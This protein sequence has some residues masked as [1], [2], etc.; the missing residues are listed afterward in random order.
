MIMIRNWR[1]IALMAVLGTGVVAAQ[2]AQQ[3]QQTPPPQ[4][5]KPGPCPPGQVEVRPGQCRTPEFAPPSIVDYHPRS[6]LV[7]DVHMVPKAKYPVIDLHGHPQQLLN[8]VDGI[9][10]IV[11]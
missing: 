7:T 5:A 3:T 10:S 4:T 1:A 9:N 2:Q 11:A 8:S 6:T